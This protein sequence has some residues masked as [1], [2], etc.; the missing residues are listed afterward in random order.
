MKKQFGGKITATDKLAYQ[1]SAHWDGE[2]FN[3]LE[4]TP[5]EIPFKALPKLIF[6]Q[7]VKPKGLLPQKTIQVEPIKLE[8]FH[9]E[10]TSMKF[11]WLGH[12]AILARINNKTIVIDPM[13]GDNAAPISPFPI[14]RYNSIDLNFLD[15]LPNIDLMLLSHD[16]YDHLDFKSIQHLKGK[17]AHYFVAL[18]VARHLIAWGIK[19]EKITEFDWWEQQNFEGI[20][21]TFTPTRHF[22]G[23]GIKDRFKSL[24]GGWAFQ[25][26]TENNWFSGDGGYGTHFKEIGKRLGPF[27]FAFMECGQYNELWRPIHLFPDEC[28]QAAIDAKAQ[29]IMPFH[30]ASFNLSNHGW[31][32]SVKAF[33]QEAEKENIP[34]LTPKIGEIFC[35]SEMKKNEFWWSK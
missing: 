34:Y 16:H 30:W 20:N 9:E 23:R 27:D 29:K 31:D 32:A 24:W 35:P 5:M 12:A 17:V 4:A 22:S 10:K 7:I 1:R 26:P 6:N 21:I 11:C 33:V 25:T 3:N 15:T 2:K 13:L 14:K 19:P 28:I 18:G 8:D